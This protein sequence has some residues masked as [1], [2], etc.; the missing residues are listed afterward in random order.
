[1]TPFP[2]PA[3]KS[4]PPGPWEIE[5]NLVEFEAH[6]LACCVMRMSG[7]NL[8]GYVRVPPAR[9][10]LSSDSLIAVPYGSIHI[11]GSPVRV[12]YAYDVIEVHGGITNA[13]ETLGD[14]W[15]GFDTAHSYDIVPAYEP[16]SDAEYR[17]LAYVCAQTI[18]LARQ[19]K[20]LLA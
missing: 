8:N 11:I 5:P 2:P 16:F 1:M 15:V 17:D 4:L 19:I 20:D 10:G 3:V 14:W 9:H 6:G 12:S 7:G 18:D 13:R